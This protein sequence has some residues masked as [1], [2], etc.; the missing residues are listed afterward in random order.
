M[1]AFQH[2]SG[3]EVDVIQRWYSKNIQALSKLFGEVLYDEDSFGWVIIR[4][5]RLP[6]FYNRS[7]TILLIETPGNNISNATAFSFYV[8][9]GLRRPDMTSYVHIYEGNGYNRY[10]DLGL[11]RLSLHIKSFRPSADGY[12]GDNLIDIAQNVYNFLALRIGL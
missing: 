2:S 4:H 1:I 3:K 11:A 8:E 7:T 5:F 12:S 10:A 6:S 9:Q